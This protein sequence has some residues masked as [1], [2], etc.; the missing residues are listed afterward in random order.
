VEL[1]VES[2]EPLDEAK[3]SPDFDPMEASQTLDPDAEEPPAAAAAAAAA[4]A[5]EPAASLTSATI[6][7]SAAA[8]AAAAAATTTTTPSGSDF[9][10]ETLAADKRA[11]LQVDPTAAQKA[12][13]KKKVSQFL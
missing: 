4:T 12:Q 6:T 9:L 7:R 1:V 8:A 5:A 11:L 13:T 10:T 3:T 2:S